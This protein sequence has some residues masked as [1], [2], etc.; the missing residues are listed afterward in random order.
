MK[1]NKLF[2]ILL[3]LKLH[4]SD[5]VDMI[6]STT[7]NEKSNA[8]SDELID[9][10]ITAENRQKIAEF[11]QKLLANEYVIYTKTLK[12]HWNV[13]GEFFGPLHTLFG[14]QYKELLSII[15]E[16]A[17]RIRAL[18]FKSTGTLQEFL[19]NTQLKEVPGKN[20][21]YNDMIK[22]LLTDHETIIKQIRGSIDITT[23]TNDVGTNNFLSD[24]IE[25]HEKIAWMLRAHLLK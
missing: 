8:I 6:V 11:L 9:I 14:E 20:P 13:I 21:V 15:D 4:A 16:V 7:G 12:Y 10:G 5:T 18:G 24:L 22:D 19:S 25:K 17:E 1:L 3:T 2:I 23:Q